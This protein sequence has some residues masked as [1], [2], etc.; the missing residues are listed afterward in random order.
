[1]RPFA[2][3]FTTLS[4][5]LCVFAAHHGNRGDR[6][7]DLAVRARWDVLQKRDFSGPFTTYDITTGMYVPQL[8][9]HSVCLIISAVR[10]A[11]EDIVQTPM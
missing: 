10:L 2:A 4:L 8:C 11:V 3:I 9:P 5:P 7:L 1:M 6:H